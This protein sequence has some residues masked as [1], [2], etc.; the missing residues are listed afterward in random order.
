MFASNPTSRFSSSRLQ[1]AVDPALEISLVSTIT[2]DFLW[3]KKASRAGRVRFAIKSH[4]TTCCALLQETSERPS[5]AGS[6]LE[7]GVIYHSRLYCS[8]DP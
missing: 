4:A 2:R 7:G 6:S 3:L 8:F 5:L 1:W